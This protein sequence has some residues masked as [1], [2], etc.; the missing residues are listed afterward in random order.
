MESA[1]IPSGNNDRLNRYVA[2]SV[3]LLAALM[4]VAKIKDD[5]I[6][7]AMVQSKS[8][9][10]DAWSEYQATAIKQHV[11]EATLTQLQV[12]TT[13]HPELLSAFEKDIKKNEAALDKYAAERVELKAKAEK[14]DSRYDELNFRDDQFD[15]SDAF[16]SIALALF[17]VTALLGSFGLLGFAWIFGTL[18]SLMGFA[19]LCGWSIHPDWLVKLLS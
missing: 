4:G 2:I 11:T 12:A 15:L 1:D 6:C 16:L 13:T 18:G 5:N 10:V 9:A 14:L 3:A 19:G 8:E 7:Q 17:A